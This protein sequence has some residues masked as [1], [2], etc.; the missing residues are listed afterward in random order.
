MVDCSH[1]LILRANKNLHRPRFFRAKTTMNLNAAV[2]EQATIRDTC[3][4]YD[5]S[6][7]SSEYE[8]KTTRKVTS[9]IKSTGLAFLPQIR[10]YFIVIRQEYSYPKPPIIYF[11]F[12]QYLSGQL[13]ALDLR[14]LGEV[15]YLRKVSNLQY[16]QRA[17]GKQNLFSRD[18]TFPHNNNQSTTEQ[19]HLWNSQTPKQQIAFMG[20][21]CSN[22]PGE[23][24]K[25]EGLFLHVFLFVT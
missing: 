14:S 13:I 9:S 17:A 3:D 22:N 25:E 5:I 16:I 12:G 7:T 10:M 2:M 19:A 23:S 1:R 15:V 6:A 11:W 20:I 8:C 21:F 4:F 24:S 18:P